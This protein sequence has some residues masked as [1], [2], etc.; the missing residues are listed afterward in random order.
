LHYFITGHTGFKGGWI[1]LLLRSLGH[2]VS[3]YSLPAAQG[4]F[5]ERAELEQEMLN[6]FEGDVRNLKDLTAAMHKS[7]PDFAIHMA[8]QALVLRS[9]E[10]PIG[11]YS[12]N[13]D[14]TRNFL[15]AI[16]SLQSP[17]VSLVVTTDKVYRDNGKGHYDEDD[18]LGGHDPYSASK[19]M[20]D[21]L[22]QSWAATNPNLRLNVA[23]AGNVIGAFDA[24]QN[25]L[26]PDVVRALQSGQTLMVRQPL[27]VRPW[28]HVLDCLTGYLLFLK[29]SDEGKTLPVSLN[30][31]PDSS[32]IK[33][34]SH[35]L[36]A[37]QA[38]YQDLK[39]S[40]D[41]YLENPKETQHL[42]LDSSKSQSFLNW[43]NLIDFQDAVSW[44]LSE[45]HGGEPLELA[46]RQVAEFLLRGAGKW[47]R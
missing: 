21:L 19:A 15:E 11:T 41:V 44:S 37:A 2:E 22:T 35:L 40:E 1:V 8:A 12:T 38:A 16:T 43:R 27:A 45:L 29:A 30:F 14:G 5:F 23:R 28:Q 20:A 25:R 24:S 10:D 17:P 31:G 3:G 47:L 7:A 42:T 6:H 18:A 36:E 9:Y 32:S 46:K 33:S 26:I 13:V 4:S 39:V 34:V